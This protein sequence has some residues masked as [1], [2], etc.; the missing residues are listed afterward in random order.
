MP[1]REFEIGGKEKEVTEVGLRAQI[2]STAYRCR[3]RVAPDNVSRDRVRV[4]VAGETNGIDNFYQEVVEYCMKQLGLPPD[5]I[6]GLRDYTGLEPDWA[7]Y[8]AM[9]DAEQTAKGVE[10]LRRTHGK[11]EEIDEKFGSIGK[12]MATVGEK[13][14]T[15]VE[16]LSPLAEINKTLQDIGTALKEAQEKLGGQKSP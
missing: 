1:I 16:R 9:F 6:Q 7:A 14:D 12:N 15:L 8:A 3:L 2:Y 10:Y 5:S 13:L 4:V 11:L